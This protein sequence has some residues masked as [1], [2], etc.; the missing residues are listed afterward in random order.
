MDRGT[1]GRVRGDR[2]VKGGIEKSG[3]G[4]QMRRKEEWRKERGM[5]KT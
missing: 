2:R 3:D 5:R 4:M 1:G